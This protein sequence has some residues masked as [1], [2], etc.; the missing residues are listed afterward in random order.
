MLKKTFTLALPVIM[1]VACVSSPNSTEQPAYTSEHPSL[2]HSGTASWLYETRQPIDGSTP[3]AKSSL[4]AASTP[5]LEILEEARWQV[6]HPNPQ[7]LWNRLFRQFYRR[8]TKDGME[9]GQDVLDPLLWSDT[10]YLLDGP[11]HQQAIEILDEFLGS[12]GE[13]LIVDPLKRAMLQRDLWAVFDWLAF[14][15]DT[16]PRQR[17]ALQER[18]AQLIQKLALTQQEILSLPDNY[19][20]AVNSKAFPTIYQDDHPKAAFL[21]P[22]LFKPNS[23]WVLVGRKNGPLAMSHTESFPFF[24]RSGFLV[25]I[26]VPG[27]REAT[28]NFLHQLNTEHVSTLQI[29]TEVALVR[30][31]MLIDA[32]GN[33]TLSPL[34]ESAQVRHFSPLQSYYEFGLSRALLFDGMTG[35]L[36]SIDKEVVLFSSHGFDLFELDLVEEAAIPEFCKACHGGDVYGIQSILSYSRTR[37]PLPDQKP[38]VL[39]ETTSEIEAQAVIM[40]K[41]KHQTWQHLATLWDQ[42]TP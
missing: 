42:E 13:T 38:P 23:E 17:R 39:V 11:S 24:G 21:P 20:A 27:G 34:I 8:A 3:P 1:L 12:K 4:V 2:P 36:R 37:F 7:H 28:L 25:F 41:L 16:Y 19:E 33:M 5:T 35:G 9:Y 29:G 18:L 40:W 31:M 10:T 15:P 14:Q 26:R 32:D 6:Y 22:D 30:R